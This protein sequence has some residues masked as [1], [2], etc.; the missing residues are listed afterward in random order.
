MGVRRKTGGQILLNGKPARLLNPAALLRTESLML[1]DRSTWVGVAH[2]VERIRRGGAQ[3]GLESFGFIVG[4]E[5]MAL[6]T[7]TFEDCRLQVSSREQVT[8]L[9]L[10]AI[11]EQS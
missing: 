8:R 11:A 10:A 3:R 9:F 7:I 2:D 5:N 4:T 1:E 6:R